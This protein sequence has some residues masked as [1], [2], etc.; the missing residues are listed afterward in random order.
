MRRIVLCD[1][2]L[3]AQYGSRERL[4]FLRS[5]FFFTGLSPRFLDSGSQ[6]S[7]NGSPRTLHTSMVWGQSLNLLSNF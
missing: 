2:L 6:P 3:A 7:L 5:T 1:L 4:M